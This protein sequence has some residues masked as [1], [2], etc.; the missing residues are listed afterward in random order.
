MKKFVIIFLF[1]SIYADDFLI[2]KGTVLD[3]TNVGESKI[4]VKEVSTEKMK[5]CVVKLNNLKSK[6]SNVG[7]QLIFES[8]V[9]VGE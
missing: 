1:N 2:P 4:L 3:F 9:N 7:N 6:V 8:C 5:S